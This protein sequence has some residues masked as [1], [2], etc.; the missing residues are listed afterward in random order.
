[1]VIRILIQCGRTARVVV[2]ICATS[3]IAYAQPRSPLDV[4]GQGEL[5]SVSPTEGWQT[6]VVAIK[7]GNAR[8]YPIRV[9]RSE[10]FLVTPGRWSAALGDT[11]AK[12][13]RF[14]GNSP[15]VEPGENS[16]VQNHTY[17]CPASH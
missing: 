10:E 14:F 6:I 1:M 3:P 12:E 17:L 7:V 15:L 16:Y 13:K 4:F 8:A 11:I 5:K 9:T 2:L